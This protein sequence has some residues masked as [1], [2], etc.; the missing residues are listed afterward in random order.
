MPKL[1]VAGKASATDQ[2]AGHATELTVTLLQP[3]R[4]CCDDAPG[5]GR[6]AGASRVWAAI[7]HAQMASW[8]Q[9]SSE[10]TVP[11]D[12]A[13]GPTPGFLLQGPITLRALA[14]G[15]PHPRAHRQGVL[16]TH[17]THPRLQ[18]QGAPGGPGFLGDGR[19][20]SCCRQP[21]T[22]PESLYSRLNFTWGNSRPK[23]Q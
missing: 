2:G 7:C 14:P 5:G 13:P 8:T 6:V 9:P 20:A 22:R 23:A 17:P 11:W 3:P 12:R 16:T 4:P 21:S 19:M 1:G 18:G 10:D 15:A